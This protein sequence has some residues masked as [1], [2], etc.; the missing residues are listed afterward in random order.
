[1]SARDTFPGV[2]QEILPA[3]EHAS[4]HFRDAISA[5]EMAKAC[6][7]SV[8][9]LQQTFRDNLGMTPQDFVMRLRIDQSLQM[10]LDSNLELSF[11]ATDCGF[12]DQS[13][14]SRKFRA[15]MGESP[16]RYRKRVLAEPARIAVRASKSEG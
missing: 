14:F 16:L 3:V 4:L 7:I 15:L 2:V 6:R 5:V 1:M 11:I 8:R 10:M 13:A 9:K 12:A